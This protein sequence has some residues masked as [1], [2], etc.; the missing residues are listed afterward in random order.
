[1]GKSEDALFWQ[2]Q[3]ISLENKLER[4]QRRHGTGVR[5]GLCSA[6]MEIILSDIKACREELRKIEDWE[7]G[8]Q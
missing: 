4:I 2:R 3:I 6:D 1:M 5:S 8:Q 7:N